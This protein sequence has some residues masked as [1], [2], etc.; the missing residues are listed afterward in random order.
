MDA[1]K[2][3]KFWIV[4]GLIVIAGGV[5]LGVWFAPAREKSAS[6]LREWRTKESK[7]KSYG[8]K[9][10][11]VR[12][13]L[14]IDAAK[15][16]R[17]DYDQQLGQ[18]KQLLAEWDKLLEDY[19][20]DLDG[21]PRQ[22][23]RGAWSLV[24]D[25]K[26]AEL[27]DEA[28]RTFPVAPAPIVSKREFQAWPSDQEMRDEAKRYW[29]QHYL[30]EAIGKANKVSDIIPTLKRFALVERPDRL[31]GVD[32]ASMFRPIAF[33]FQFATE[34]KHL[35]MVLHRILECQVP[36]CITSVSMK[37][38]PKVSLAAKSSEGTTGKVLSARDVSTLLGAPS[39]PVG[40][41]RG[42]MMPPMYEGP[43]IWDMMGP[44]GPPPEEETRAESGSSRRRRGASTVA[45]RTSPTEPSA[46]AVA[47]RP[48]EEVEAGRLLLDI[49]VRGYVKD[50][51]PPAETESADAAEQ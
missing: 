47:K 8:E 10:N 25:T 6:S 35:P 16:L 48:Q 3:M 34:F 29:V 38:R 2:R 24:Y 39:G 27:E 26:M 19:I 7:V 51:I 50:Y 14:D 11:G 5:V 49:T 42:P 20:P 28:Q 31:L 4:A 40:M 21:T 17:E 36:V 30:L 9:I 33:E 15:E 32:D 46:P 22:L 45:R 43:S 12:G 23:D 18:A 37:R 44:M 1:I 13:S 41:A